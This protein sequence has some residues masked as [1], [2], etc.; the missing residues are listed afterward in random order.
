MVD[1]QIDR[2]VT[3]HED[4]G[5]LIG[6]RADRRGEGVRPARRPPQR[7]FAA[8]LL[9][10][11]TLGE[12]AREETDANAVTPCVDDLLCAVEDVGREIAVHVPGDRADLT[13]AE[14]DR[15]EMRELVAT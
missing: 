3:E 9:R 15:A 12:P 8:R 14:R 13:I 11:S 1:L 5:D 10:A 6:V 2:V 4:R 7:R